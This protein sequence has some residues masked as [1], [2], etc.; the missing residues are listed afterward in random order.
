MSDKVQALMAQTQD[1]EAT[2][3]LFA[4]IE[5]AGQAGAAG[6]FLKLIKKAKAEIAAYCNPNIERWHQGH[7]AAVAQK[8]ELEAP[9]VAL[10]NTIKRAV[11]NWTVAEQHRIASERA[12]REKAARAAAEAE[13]QAEAARAREEG[14]E[15]TA[16]I[17]EAMPVAPIVD[18]VEDKPKIEGV[19]TRINW[20]AE[21]IDKKKL[22]E[23]VL[24][25]W[26]A[27]NHLVEPSTKEL[28]KMAKAQKENFH[29]PGAKAVGEKSTVVR[30]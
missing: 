3:N 4:K 8:K 6:E 17:I 10:E 5:T 2:A 25:N 23:Y 14:D 16:E 29:V 21:V 30:G 18:K 12:Q 13:R 9:L 28:N 11:S 27:L 19:H 24:E 1:L 20:K 22:V 7:K 26:T 15:E